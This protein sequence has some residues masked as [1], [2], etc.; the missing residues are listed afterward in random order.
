MCVS[1][2]HGGTSVKILCRK[3]C[4]MCMPMWVT[5]PCGGR[6]SSGRYS[7]EHDAASKSLSITANL[8]SCIINVKLWWLR[9]SGSKTP[10]FDLHLSYMLEWLFLLCLFIACFSVAAKSSWPLLPCST[11]QSIQAFVLLSIRKKYKHMCGKNAALV[12]MTV[13]GT[14]LIT[15]TM[16]PALQELTHVKL[17]QK[18]K[19][20]LRFSVI[21]TGAS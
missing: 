21:I 19:K 8:T 11:A 6:K 7:Y 1:C 10:I 13:I 18:E 5:A 16:Q 17:H 9:N 14:D 12:P 15:L 4:G 2:Q 20:S 3:A